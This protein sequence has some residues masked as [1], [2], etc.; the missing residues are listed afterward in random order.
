MDR[1]FL[2]DDPVARSQAVAALLL[3][4]LTSVGAVVV[5]VAVFDLEERVL[6]I[7]SPQVQFD[8][9]Y[10]NETGT[11]VVVHHSGD[12]IDGGRV[13]FENASG[14]VVGNWS[15]ESEVTAG[16]AVAVRAVRPNE[17]IRIRWRGEEESSLIG[18]WEGSEHNATAA[19]PETANGSIIGEARVVFGS[20]S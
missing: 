8:F 9:E 6:G 4:V 3:V 10:Q 7:Q 11:L 15:N 17:T 16:D 5:G 1:R 12:T 20:S 13:V 2:D 19:E 14:A 18:E